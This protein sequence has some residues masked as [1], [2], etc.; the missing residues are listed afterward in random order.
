M[1]IRI[2]LPP[3]LEERFLAQAR[4][5][6]VSV[7][8]CVEEFLARSIRPSMEPRQLSAE[9][10]DRLFEEAADLVPPGVPPLSDEAMSREGIYTREDEW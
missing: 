7:G 2:E 1:T 6:G 8:V 4:A 9:D 10:V 3:E 5:R